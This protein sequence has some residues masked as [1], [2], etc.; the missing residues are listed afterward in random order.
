M[1]STYVHLREEYF[2]STHRVMINPYMMN[3]LRK[4]LFSHSVH[5]N[6]KLRQKEAKCVL[7]FNGPLRLLK[8]TLG[9]DY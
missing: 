6:G 7:S 1:V 2:D 8:G 4:V 5:V 9:L 3:G